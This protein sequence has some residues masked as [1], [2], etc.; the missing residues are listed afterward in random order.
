SLTEPVLDPVA[1]I[2]R[3]QRRIVHEDA[4]PGRPPPRLRSVQEVQPPTGALRRLPLLAQLGEEAVQLAGRHARGVLLELLLDP[5]EQPL[6]AAA[7]PRGDGDQR[8]GPPPPPAGPPPPPP[9]P[10]PPHL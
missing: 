3:Q 1:V 4:E 7:C 2:S 6:D 10:P 8:R 5:A 9:P